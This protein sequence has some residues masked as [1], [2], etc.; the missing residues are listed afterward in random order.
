M[1]LKTKLLADLSV[2]TDKVQNSAVTTVKVNDLAITE[3]KLADDAVTSDKVATQAIVSEHLD[4]SAKQVVLEYKHFAYPVA[5]ANFVVTNGATSDDAT[6][7]I[8]SRSTSQRTGGYASGKGVITTPPN[9]RVFFREVNTNDPVQTSNN[10]EVYG[11]TTS[12]VTAINGTVSWFQGSASLSGSGTNFTAELAVG[13]W[14]KLDSDGKLYKIAGIPSNSDITLENIYTGTTGSGASSK[15]EIVLSYYIDVNGTETSHTMTGMTVDLLFGEVFDL[16][17]APFNSPLVMV[18]FAEILSGEHHHDTRYHTQNALAST[19]NGSSGASLIGVDSSVLSWT[20]ATNLQ[21]ILE[22]IDTAFAKFSRHEAITVTA[23]NTVADLTYTPADDTILLMV[24]GLP[25]A[26]T[27][28]VVSGKSITWNSG[29]AGFD[30]EVT[31]D[32]MAFYQSTD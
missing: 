5:G 4:D 31:D 18:G 12:V 11:R 22:E 26:P 27:D 29:N 19:A 10:E 13:D 30:L 23:L 15:E 6:D 16:L 24:S 32:V 28:Y 7:F 2:T 17:N 14:I 20:S 9:N 21:A 8:L 25:Q 3:P 1:Q